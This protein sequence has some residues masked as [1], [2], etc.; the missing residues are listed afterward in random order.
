MRLRSVPVTMDIL[1]REMHMGPVD[2]SPPFLI[3][4]SL[5]PK[6]ESAQSEGLNSSTDSKQGY[7]NV[8]SSSHR[9]KDRT[10]AGVQPRCLLVSS[11]LLMQAGVERG[12]LGVSLISTRRDTLDE[13]SDLSTT[14]GAVNQITMDQG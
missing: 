2:I 12:S 5:A 4:N 7:D 3:S 10:V 13:F 6:L 9:L 14:T 1:S 11:R 8:Q